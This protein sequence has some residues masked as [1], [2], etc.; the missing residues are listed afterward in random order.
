MCQGAAERFRSEAGA[1]GDVPVAEEARGH[2]SEQVGEHV[3][4]LVEIDARIVETP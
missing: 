2:V 3:R 1:A 4:D